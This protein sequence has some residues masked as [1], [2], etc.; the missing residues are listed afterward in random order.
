MIVKAFIDTIYHW[1]TQRWA[2]MFVSK[3]S[4]L[5]FINYWLNDIY[6]FEGRWWSFM[7]RDD[8]DIVIPDWTAV[9]YY[10][11]STQYPLYKVAMI[12]DNKYNRFIERAKF[13]QIKQAVK[14]ENE[15]FFLPFRTDITLYNNVSWYVMSRLSWFNPI[16]SDT[17]FLPI[18]DSFNHALFDFV[19]AY[20]LPVYAQYWEQRENVMYQRGMN[21]LNELKKADDV[22]FS[23]IS[24][25]IK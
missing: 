18:P 21:K 20:I 19:M 11:Y 7:Y 13:K 2:T 22:Q 5:S 15:I 12:F 9:P 4:I 14:E 8:T 25:N 6:S 1:L 3:E 17:E 24:F 10:T 23:Q 16:V